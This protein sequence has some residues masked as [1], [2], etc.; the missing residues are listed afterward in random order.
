MK[1]D[2]KEL[3]KQRIEKE[4]SQLRSQIE[5]LRKEKNYRKVNQVLQ[6]K[7]LQYLELYT[8]GK[9]DI[10]EYNQLLRGIK[11]LKRAKRRKSCY[12]TAPLEGSGKS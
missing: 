2:L 3:K 9:L 8:S 4:I 12:G 10:E 5:Q 1:E 7:M 6:Q 11:E